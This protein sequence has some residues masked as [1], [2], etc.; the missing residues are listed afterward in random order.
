MILNEY[1]WSTL[2]VKDWFTILQISKATSQTITAARQLH[3]AFTADTQILILSIF[4]LM[5]H[6]GLH[7]FSPCRAT[8]SHP[9]ATALQRPTLAYGR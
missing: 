3:S 4:A 2:G 6:I 8:T 9:V 5:A 1:S 7:R